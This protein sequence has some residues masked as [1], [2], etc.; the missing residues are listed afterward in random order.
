MPAAG[1]FD[2]GAIARALLCDGGTVVRAGLFDLGLVAEAVLADQRRVALADLFDRGAVGVA[3]LK[4]VGLQLR[5]ALGD[6]SG[7]ALP[8][9]LNDRE[10]TLRATGSLTESG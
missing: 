7:H 6:A 3:V 5:A 2:E 8:G 4:D 1:L 10:R 9:L